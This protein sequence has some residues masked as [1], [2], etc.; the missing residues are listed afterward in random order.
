MMAGVDLVIVPYRGAGP[1]EVDVLAGQM[2][3][4]FDGMTSSIG[5][6]KSGQLKALGVTAGTRVDALPDI[7][8]IGEIVPGYEEVSWCGLTAPAATPADIVS[9]LNGEVNAALADPGVKARF[10]DLGAT[11]MG[12]TAAAFGKFIVEDTAKWAKVVEFAGIK[13]R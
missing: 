6:V 2:P 4:A 12:G 11:L 7:P 9:K 3:V 13:P 1:M 10:A 8:T 5:H